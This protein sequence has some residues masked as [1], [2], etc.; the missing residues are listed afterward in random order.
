[1]TKLTLK[2]TNF[3]IFGPFFSFSREIFEFGI[4]HMAYPKTTDKNQALRK[5]PCPKKPLQLKL[6][7][8][9]SFFTKNVNFWPFLLWKER[10]WFFS[11]ANWQC[12]Q[13]LRVNN[14]F[15]HKSKK[16]FFQNFC[17]NSVLRP[18][19]PI[20]LVSSTGVHFFHLKHAGSLKKKFQRTLHYIGQM[21]RTKGIV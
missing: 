10:N 17:L 13:L 20:L 5:N 19:F 7:F 2:N 21:W 4:F 6:W 15:Y 18:P 1:M 3:G 16:N 11:S 12:Y 8:F 9:I 14:H